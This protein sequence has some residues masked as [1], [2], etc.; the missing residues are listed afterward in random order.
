MLEV[1]MSLWPGARP[2]LAGPVK[3]KKTHYW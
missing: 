1:R 2:R 3:K